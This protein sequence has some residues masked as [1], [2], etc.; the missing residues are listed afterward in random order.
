MLVVFLIVLSIL[1]LG[2]YEEPEWSEKRIFLKHKASFNWYFP[3]PEGEKYPF[4]ESLAELPSELTDKE[5]RLYVEF[6]NE[7]KGSSRSIPF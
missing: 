4:V 7:E 3:V 2:I 6:I 5:V 1:F